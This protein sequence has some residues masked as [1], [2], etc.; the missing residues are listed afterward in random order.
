[1][2]FPPLLPLVLLA[3]SVISAATSPAAAAGLTRQALAAAGFHFAPGALLPATV[4]LREQAGQTTLGA[5]LGGKPALLVFTDYRCQS[6]CGIVLDELAETLPKV[7]LALGRDYRVISVALDSAQTLADA[8][9][10]R[11][12]HTAG[13]PLH[14]GARFFVNDASALQ[15]LQTSVGLVAPYDAD[16]RQFAHP[17]GLILVDAAGK[18]QRMLSPFA[19]NPFDLKLALL[20]TGAAPASIAGHALLLCYGFDPVTGLYTLRIERILALTA[21]A[22][23]LFI[24]SGVGIFL[25]RERRLRRRSAFPSTT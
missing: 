12:R 25:W 7:P 10:F 4:S 21:A 5:A 3:S 13:S 17:A 20:D 11:D 1:M 2:R 6:L 15:Q 16:H 22:T 19:L 14:D 18:A 9:A 24:S 23:I 8:D